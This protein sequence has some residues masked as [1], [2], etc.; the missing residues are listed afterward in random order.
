MFDVAEPKA[1]QAVISDF[2]AKNMLVSAVCHGS[3]MLAHLNT[4]GTNDS[5]LEGCQVTGISNKEIEMFLSSL[6]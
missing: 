3:A 1:S 2:H 5:M 4:P 6:V